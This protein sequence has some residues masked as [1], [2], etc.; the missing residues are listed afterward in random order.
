[1]RKIWSCLIL[2]KTLCLLIWNSV[3]RSPTWCVSKK[4]SVHESR[5]SSHGQFVTLSGFAHYCWREF[6]VTY[7]FAVCHKLSGVAL[8]DLLEIIHFHCP[9]SNNCITKLRE[10]QLFFQALKHPI[11]KHFFCP[12]GICKVYSSGTSPETGTTYT[13]SGTPLSYSLY[14]EILYF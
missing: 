7:A 11:L 13:V 4:L 10:F 2:T 8:E 1:M 9:K 5:G 14:I 3:L 6:V 12:N